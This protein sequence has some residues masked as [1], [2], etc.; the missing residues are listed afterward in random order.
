MRYVILRDDDTNASMPPDYLEK[1]YRP[2]L[3]RGLPVNLATIPNVNT[4]ATYAEGHPE[5]FLLAKKAP[6]P[7]TM[8]IG[9]NPALV[10]Y[11]LDNSGYHI[12][13]HGCRHD[14]ADRTYEFNQSNRQ[15]IA[16]R[17]DE[18]R[19]H[20]LEAGF[21]APST[22]VAPYDRLSRESLEEVARRFRI[23]STGWYDPRRLPLSWL[24]HYAMKKTLRKDHWRVG[25]TILL[26]HPG[27]HLSYHKSYVTMLDEI[28]KSIDSRRLTVLVTHWWEYFREQK[29][30]DAFISVLHETAEYLAT[31]RD[32]KVISFD[33][34]LESNVAL[35]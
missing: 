6:C 35:N 31:R 17:L 5:L 3:D 20:L 27:C 33:S 11:L 25:Q 9:S 2:F 28:K 1:L 7:T 24:P 14:S 8:P 30:D 19:R 22:F 23:L 32:L 21:K 13:Q 26:T 34:L 12:L 15:D 16:R 18:G 4:E 29:P 10:R